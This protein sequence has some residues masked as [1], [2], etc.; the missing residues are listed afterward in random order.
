MPQQQTI[1]WL[2]CDMQW[3]VDFYKTTGD[4]YLSGWTG[5]KVQSTSQSHTCTKKGHSHCLVVCCH[6]DPL[7]LSE[8]WWNHWSEYAKQINEMQWK[9]QCLQ[10]SLVNR[11]GPILLHDNT[12]PHVAQPMLQKLNRLG[13]KLLPHL[14][15]SPDLSPTDYFFQHLNSFLQRKWFHKPEGRKCFP[16]VKSRSTDFFF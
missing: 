11:K 5:K 10:P 8:S 4:D 13:Y 14:P 15:Y 12:W 6:C 2:D 7:Q 16:R 9:L 3:K 1:S